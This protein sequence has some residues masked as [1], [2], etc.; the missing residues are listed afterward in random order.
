MPARPRRS[1]GHGNLP[2][3]HR[4]RAH[5]GRRALP[6]D[7]TNEHRQSFKFENDKD[8]KRPVRLEDG[9]KTLRDYG[10]SAANILA[11]ALAAQPPRPPRNAPRVQFAMRLAT[12]AAP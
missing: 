5:A 12:A 3:P 11:A 1:E 6:A 10:V 7:R 8:P 2:A 4:T 9:A